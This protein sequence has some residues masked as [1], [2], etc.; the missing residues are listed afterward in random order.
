MKLTLPSLVF[1]FALPALAQPVW[2]WTAKTAESQEQADF[3]TEFEITGAVRSAVLNLTCDNG[4]TALINGKKVLEN[5]D[6]QK[7]SRAD[8]KAALQAGKNE[9]LV[10]ARNH[11]GSAALIAALDIELADG[12]KLTVE[13]GD[14]WL[15]A[16]H[17]APD[18]KPAVVIAKY[19]DGPWGLALSSQADKGKGKGK[20]KDAKPR[21]SNDGPDIATDPKDIT[22]PPGFKVELLYT[23]PKAEQGSW[24]S[25][26][27]DKKG[28][29][30]CGDQYGGLYRLTPPPLGSGDKAA[31]ERIEA[32]IGGAHGLLY[33]H[34][35]LY[36]MLDEGSAPEAKGMKQGL[37]R[38]KDR[39]GDDHFGDPILLS[40][41]AGS[42]EHG[43]HSI[44]L[45]PDGKNIF[46]NCGN[47]TKLPENLSGSRAAM[48]SWD[49]DHILPRMWDANGHARG[50]LAPGGYICQTDPDGKRVEMFC[51]GFRN[52]FDFAF[53][54]NGEMFAYDADMEWDIGAP[55]YRPTRINHCVSGGDYGWRSGSGKWPVYYEDSL[56]SVV[57]IG[58]GSPT[59][60]TFGTGARFPAKYQ[61]ALFGNDWTYG[62]MYAVHFEPSGASFKAVKEEFIF[63]KPL[64]LTDVVINQHDGAMYFAVGGRRTQSAVYRVTYEG[65]ESVEKAKPYELTREMVQRRELEKLHELN[66]DQLAGYG[67]AVTKSFN[68][69]DR[70]IRFAARVAMER[71]FK[72][73]TSLANLSL[74]RESKQEA[75][76]ALI[77][78][79]IG[80]ARVGRTEQHVAK[81][82]E[83]TKPAPGS[84]TAAVGPTNE[85][86]GKLQAKILEALGKLDFK[87]LS[88]DLQLQLIRAYQLAFTRL[89]KPDA[90]ACARVAAHLDPLY[91]AKEG[92]MN[93]ELCQLLIFLDSKSVA[94]KTLGLMATAHDDDVA[95]ATDALLERNTGYAK[96]A[97]EAH[98]SR[99][100]RQQ[101]AFM[102]AL[103]NCTA[104]WTPE[105]RQTYF[106]WFPHARTWKGGNSFRGF[107]ENT[108][109]EALAKF[110][111]ENEVAKLDELSGRM[112]TVV[113]ANITP[114][115]GP[116][117]PYTTDDVVKFAQGG[118]KGR[119]YASGK[120]LFGA[121]MC[122]ACHH[123]AGD[124]GNIGP[125]I[126]GAGNRY[127]IRDLVENLTEPSKVIS[128]QYG[129]HQIEKTD[130]SIVVGR[131]ISEDGGKVN[132]MT[133]PF[134]PNVLI[135]IDGKD[136]K[137]RKDY[138]VS[139]MPPGLINALNEEELKDLLAYL[140]SGGNEKD[141]MFAK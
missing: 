133:N 131:I 98:Q 109:K 108:R 141:K 99:P 102:F 120:N 93:R 12:K 53:D 5:P 104:G 47:H 43:P 39:D 112:E 31:V 94:S 46:F 106:S 100:N 125:D 57:D 58:P 80:L 82:D 2:I 30:L 110:V 95:I 35:S 117:R 33:A 76:Q 34:D 114:P 105:L 137:S 77:E 136:I 124:G 91:P 45:A 87:S 74:E 1:A 129:S 115:K 55:W 83:K 138:P 23:V 36:V 20:G 84:S 6:W 14:K 44:Q 70:N 126:T 121:M 119:D 42:G 38:L 107:L 28:R 89:G 65:K 85:A 96:A 101:I 52:E 51:S 78:T 10:Q 62:T 56:P 22:A 81:P 111:P 67:Q 59:G 37:Y 86:D 18:W 134:A 8:V 60:V 41:C 63:G 4:A 50:I 64:P 25:M 113:A 122:A 49:E 128:D 132:V 66:S 54:A 29:L 68:S 13:T 88:L 27:V 79:L 118:L 92:A 15:A 72:P 24:V 140:L 130:G 127:S 69:P 135:P 97:N 71:A 40:A 26:T 116:G 9:I 11:G 123:F 7:A 90:A 19:G 48:N 139:M 16:K 32:K 17:G 21:K 61:R 3:K 73:G 75:P 103:R